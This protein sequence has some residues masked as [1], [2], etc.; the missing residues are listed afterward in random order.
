VARCTVER[1]MRELGIAGVRRGKPRRTTIADERADR[2]AD[3]VDRN[4]SPFKPNQL[5]VADFTYVATWAGVVYVAFVIDA[6][7]RRIL[8]WKAATTMQT[9]LVLDALEMAIFTREQE[10]ITDLTGLIHHNDAGSQTR[11]N[12]WSQHRLVEARLAGH[13][14]LRRVSS[15]RVSF[16]VAS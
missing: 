1:L 7:S 16:V 8:G 14:A 12:R 15:N 10:G 13:R 9:Q 2:P 4:F 11:L 3:L 5:W 6:F